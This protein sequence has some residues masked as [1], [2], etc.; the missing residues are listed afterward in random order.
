MNFVMVGVILVTSPDLGEVCRETI[1]GGTE[2]IHE[3]VL[4]EE[5]QH[6]VHHTL[7]TTLHGV[8]LEGVQV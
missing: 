6:Q 8:N 4:S 3:I 7:L 5:E 1:I 2:H